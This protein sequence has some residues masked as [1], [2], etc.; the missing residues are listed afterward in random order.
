MLIQMTFLLLCPFFSYE[1][2]LHILAQHCHTHEQEFLKVTLLFVGY[3]L[4]FVRSSSQVLVSVETLVSSVEKQHLSHMLA[5]AST[6]WPDFPHFACDLS[7]PLAPGFCLSNASPHPLSCTTH[8]ISLF[9]HKIYACKMVIGLGVW[10]C[11]GRKEEIF[12][13]AIKKT[14]F[15]NVSWHPAT[16]H[17]STALSKW[18]FWYHRV[19]IA[20]LVSSAKIL[21]QFFL[22]I[23]P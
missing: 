6:V 1:N 11:W 12:F 13:V 19:W 2:A 7:P 17:C 18:S 14:H 4:T 23:F 5:C 20:F 10:R 22:P 8:L 21:S 3:L 15:S 9:Q 16:W